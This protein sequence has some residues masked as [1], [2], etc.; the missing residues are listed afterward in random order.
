MTGATKI[1]SFSLYG[2]MPLYTIGA[3]RNAELV[4]RI[5][6]GWRARFYVDDTVPENVIDALRARDAEIV[7]AKKKLGPMYGR[8]WRTLVASDPD[9]GRF[10]IRDC[11][12]RLNWRERAA[13]DEWLASGCSFHIMRDSV[14]HNTRMLSGMWG[15][16]GGIIKNMD[17]LID[18][19][20]KYSVQGENDQFASEK[21]FPLIEHDYICHDSCGH[22]PDARPFPQHAAL[23]GKTFVGD[24]MPI[25]YD[26]LEFSSLPD[27]SDKKA[28]SLNFEI[29]AVRLQL[30]K[31]KAERDELRRQG[32]SKE[33]ALDR[34]ARLEQIHTLTTLL[35][36]SEL[37][38][39][40]RLEQIHTLTA[41]LR[42]S[43][44][45]RGARL[46]QI[47]TLTA[48]LEE[49]ERDRTERLKQIQELTKQSGRGGRR[50]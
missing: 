34:D 20:G 12:S 37:D 39:G 25:D 32:A 41:L 19:W 10:I 26:D 44:L 45:D 1:V 17:L 14:A 27:N 38:R 29:D 48:L 3:V 6:P 4:H 46:E 8:H 16:V 35:E 28:N 9:V 15:G 7:V 18:S 2:A 47:H 42:E 11:D 36:E 13:V 30:A 21:I 43:E 31:V 24:I 33:L 49:S 22:F 50:F 40:A 23:E 5:Y